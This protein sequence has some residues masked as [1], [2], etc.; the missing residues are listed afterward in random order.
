MSINETE[1]T[2]TSN[3]DLVQL[4]LRIKRDDLTPAIECNNSP[5]KTKQKLKGNK[6]PIR[7]MSGSH[8]ERLKRAA[9]EKDNVL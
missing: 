4:N 1:K 7:P 2:S 5:P 9:R 8:Y 6:R 3:R